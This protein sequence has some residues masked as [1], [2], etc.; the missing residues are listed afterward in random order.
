MKAFLI[1]LQFLSRI[2]LASQSVWRDEDFGRSVLFFP[3]VGLI[4]GLLLAALYW[5]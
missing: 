3:L 5:A 2:H 4:I 1:A